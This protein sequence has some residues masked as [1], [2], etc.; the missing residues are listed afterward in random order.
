VS[1][2]EVVTATGAPLKVAD[3]VHTTPLPAEV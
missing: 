3:D 2:D 1:V